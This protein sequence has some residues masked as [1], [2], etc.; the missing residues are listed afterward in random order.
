MLKAPRRDCGGASAMIVG[1]VLGA[2]A[3]GGPVAAETADKD[4]FPDI[5][6]AK[7]TSRGGEIFDF[8][9]TVSSPYDTAARYADAFRVMTTSGAVLGER[10]LLHDHKDEQPF[11]RDL[12]GVRVPPG[13]VSVTIQGRDLKFG[14]GGKTIEVAVPGR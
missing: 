12:Y 6:A 11:I 5:L 2:L 10:V 4:K 13:I 1:A 9:V 3:L 7:V 14:W 8:D